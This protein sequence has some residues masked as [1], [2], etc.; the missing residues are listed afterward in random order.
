MKKF[1]YVIVLLLPFFGCKK[2]TEIGSNF[3]GNNSNNKI[4]TY[5][6]GDISQ[7]KKLQ[8]FFEREGKADGKMGYLCYRSYSSLLS[9]NK[10]RNFEGNFTTEIFKN[11]FI[12][13][14]K[15]YNSELTIDKDKKFVFNGIPNENIFGH[16][17]KFSNENTFSLGTRDGNWSESLYVPMPLNLD[18]EAIQGKF[19]KANG[20]NLKWQVDSKNDKGVFIRIN[21]SP[22]YQS[23]KKQSG[24]EINKIIAIPD[25]GSYKLTSEDLK[26]FQSPIGALSIL[27]YRGNYIVSS[28]QNSDIPLYIYDKVSFNLSLE[29]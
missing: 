5:Y 9:E 20:L 25:I 19:S 17:V 24:T 12:S 1:I 28:N 26:E 8:S 6:G 21:Y 14:E 7:L 29:N 16:T 23:P 27:V 4:I 15:G 10:A 11:I 22:E 18:H 2:N 13:N 3:E